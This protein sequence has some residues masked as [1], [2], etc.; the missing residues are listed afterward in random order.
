MTEMAEAVRRIPL[1]DGFEGEIRDE[2][3]PMTGD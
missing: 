1:E 2:S 3:V